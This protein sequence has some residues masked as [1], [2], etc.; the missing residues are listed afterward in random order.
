M[1]NDR[2]TATSVRAPLHAKQTSD[3]M[4]AREGLPDAA[5]HSTVAETTR[6][7]CLS[8]VPSAQRQRRLQQLPPCRARVPNARR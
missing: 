5:L 8:H 2:Y 6:L 4:R 1:T 3:R 7:S